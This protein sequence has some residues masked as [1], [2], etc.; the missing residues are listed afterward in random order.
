ML[1]QVNASEACNHVMSSVTC[2]MPGQDNTYLCFVCARHE[3]ILYT[4]LN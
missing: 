4:T 2:A 3:A 1:P